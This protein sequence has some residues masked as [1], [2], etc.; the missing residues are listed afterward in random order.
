MQHAQVPGPVKYPK[1]MAFTPL[2]W[3]GHYFRYLGGPGMRHDGSGLFLATFGGCYAALLLTLRV[4]GAWLWP[5]LTLC[6]DPL[7]PK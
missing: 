7:T 2:F 4:V 1:M 3:D 6:R 5:P